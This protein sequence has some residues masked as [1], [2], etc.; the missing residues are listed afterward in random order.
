MA[1]IHFHVRRACTFSFNGLTLVRYSFEYLARLVATLIYLL[2]IPFDPP[3]H[4]VPRA[5]KIAQAGSV[6]IGIPPSGDP[7]VC[8]PAVCVKHIART[9][10][11]ACVCAHLRHVGSLFVPRAE[12]PAVSASLVLFVSPRPSPTRRDLT[13]TTTIPLPR[14]HA[15]IASMR[16]SIDALRARRE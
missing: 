15:S 6:Y 2:S 10:V 16:V 14:L 9:C 1:R 3:W 13:I 12:R 4:R 5:R 11:P 7:S 8:V